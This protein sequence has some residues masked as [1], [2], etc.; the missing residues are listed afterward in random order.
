MTTETRPQDK[1]RSLF[2]LCDTAVVEANRHRTCYRTV[3]EHLAQRHSGKIEGG[4]LATLVEGNDLF[5]I[6]MRPTGM[7]RNL[8]FIGH[9]FNEVVGDAFD[10]AVSLS[11]NVCPQGDNLIHTEAELNATLNFIELA[12]TC[13]AEVRVAFNEWRDEEMSI[14]GVKQVATAESSLRFHLTMHPDDADYMTEPF[15]AAMSDAGSESV[16][17]IHAYPRNP[18]G[19]FAFYALNATTG[20]RDMLMAAKADVRFDEVPA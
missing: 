16:F 1:L 7:P 10:M 20:I 6:N 18:V 12:K 9:D 17:R 13:R 8:T 19:S 11:T 2:L 15:I 14:M 3:A 4:A 5:T